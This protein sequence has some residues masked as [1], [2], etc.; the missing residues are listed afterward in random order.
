MAARSA[1]Q[2]VQ[3]EPEEVCPLT[4]ALTVG[5]QGGVLVP[6]P[7]VLNVVIAFRASG[8]NDT[9][10]TWGVF[11]AMLIAVSVLPIAFDSVRDLT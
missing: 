1:D 4:V 11:A 5:F 6:A 7:T 9:Y 2:P 3:F 8:L 10:L